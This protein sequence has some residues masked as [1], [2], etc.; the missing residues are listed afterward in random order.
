[1]LAHFAISAVT[2][3]SRLPGRDKLSRP[4]TKTVEELVCRGRMSL[5]LYQM[6]DP[7]RS[8]KRSLFQPLRFSTLSK[9]KAVR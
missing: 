8:W 7:A 6:L 4:A 9:P 3:F 5:G 1:L 2:L